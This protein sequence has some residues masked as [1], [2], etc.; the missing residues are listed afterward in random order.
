M[1]SGELS[2]GVILCVGVA[3]LFA[4]ARASSQDPTATIVQDDVSCANCT[5]VLDAVA[6]LG[7]A[8]GP[9]A[10]SG[11]SSVAKLADGRYALTDTY[12]DYEIK[13]FT[14]EGLFSQVVG[15]RGQGPSE[16]RFARSVYASGDEVHVID[17]LARRRTIF[18]RNFQFLRLH[19]FAG[20]MIGD[21]LPLD[22]GWFVINARIFSR[23]LVSHVL[24]VFDEGGA[25]VTSMD[26]SREGFRFDKPD[27][28]YFRSLARSARGF[29]SAQQTRYRI[30]EWNVEGSRLRSIE[31]ASSWFPEHEG[32]VGPPLPDSPPRPSL[33]AIRE[34]A[35]GNLWTLIRVASDQW[36]EALAP[37]PPSAHPE[38]GQYVLGD[39]NRAFDSVIEILDVGE[40]AVI[41]SVRFDEALFAFVGDDEVVAPSWV[42]VNGA[43]GSDFQLRILRAVFRER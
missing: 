11:I 6:T 12:A 31:R 10:L 42:G 4:D 17:P 8:S 30:D 34:D 9:G 16:F 36:S 19:G 27:G 37:A 32:S 43:T 18:S 33:L 29:W 20:S 14:R 21:V 13:V 39:L 35:D 2:R 28:P 15:R 23:D 40:G 25:I 7:D 24:H 1:S 38:V 22:Q 3:V 5:V 41:T 26:E